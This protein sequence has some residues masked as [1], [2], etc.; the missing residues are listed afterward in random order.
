[1]QV[2][3]SNGTQFSTSADMQNHP[4]LAVLIPTGYTA[5]AVAIQA[6][7]D[8]VTFY[9]L[10]DSNGNLVTF[11]APAGD[12]I[13][14]LTGTVQQALISLNWFRL[15]SAAAVTADRTFVFIRKTVR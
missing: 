1:M 2:T 6:S 11:Q 15:K 14:A 10:Y 13:V 5:G 7:I 12:T 8:G 4:F 9:D 3:I